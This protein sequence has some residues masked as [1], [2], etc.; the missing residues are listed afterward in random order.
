MG[1]GSLLSDAEEEIEAQSLNDFSKV[2]GLQTSL[3]GVR[4]GC[5]ANQC[6]RWEL[7]DCQESQVHAQNCLLPVL[8]VRGGSS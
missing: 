1:T 4:E 5:A 6:G 8:D 3:T 2:S 7:C